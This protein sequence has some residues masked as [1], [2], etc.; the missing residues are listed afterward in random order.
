MG[1]ISNWKNKNRTYKGTASIKLTS[2]EEK[3]I[4]KKINLGLGKFDKETG[5]YMPIKK[6]K[7]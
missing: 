6:V 7:K 2:D 5:T 1:D 4:K 3:N